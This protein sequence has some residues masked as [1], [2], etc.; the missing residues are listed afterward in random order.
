MKARGRQTE[1]QEDRE[2]LSDISH[3]TERLYRP[4]NPLV[5]GPSC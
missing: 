3:F 4:S 1:Q 5:H 2:L